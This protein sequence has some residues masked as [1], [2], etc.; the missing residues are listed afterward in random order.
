MLDV[1]R[2]IVSHNMMCCTQECIVPGF[3]LL[4]LLL[5]LITPQMN[6]NEDADEEVPRGRRMKGAQ[7]VVPASSRSD[8]TPAAQQQQSKMFE[9]G[10]C[11]LCGTLFTS[12]LKRRVRFS[13]EIGSPKS[14][15]LVQRQVFYVVV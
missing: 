13:F 3:L 8:G 11:Y 7:I 10:M 6:G 14:P 2:N 4:L 15:F 1:H 12:V 9:S 5:L